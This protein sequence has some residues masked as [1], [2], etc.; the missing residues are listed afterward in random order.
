MLLVVTG[1][2]RPGDGR[3]VVVETTCVQWRPRPCVSCHGRDSWERHAY[4]CG[5]FL[6]LY[7]TVATTTSL[8]CMRPVNREGQ[9]VCTFPSSCI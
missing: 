4:A 5:R 9:P 6:F 7:G 8:P 2:R 3:V 1:G